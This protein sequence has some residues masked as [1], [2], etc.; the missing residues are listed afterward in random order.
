M[1]SLIML[2]VVVLA[3]LAVAVLAGRGRSF[4]MDVFQMLLRDETGAISLAEAAVLSQNDLQRGVIEAFIYE[5]Y[6][7]DRI[8]LLPIEGNAYAYNVELT[9]PGAAF[10]AVNAGYT[11]STGTVNQLT[12]T[13]K[14]LGGDADV[15]TF[16]Q[17]TRSNLNDQRAIQTTMKVKAA[18]VAYQDAFINGDTAVDA[19]E[20]DG[21]KKRLTG[22]QVI[23]TATNGLPIIGADDAARHLFLDKLDEAIDAVNGTPAALYMNRKAR[24]Q[25]RSSARRLGFWDRTRDEFGRRVETYN[26]IP[27]LDL[28]KDLAGADI[29]TVTETQ[30][31]SNVSSSIYV[32]AWSPDESQAGVTGLTNGGVQVR[33]LGEQDATPVLRTRIEFFC[34][35]AVFG[36]GASRLRGVLTP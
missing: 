16:I 1:Q 27:M 7:L 31:S 35:L 2:T 25:L 21:L 34:G 20:F 19:N 3:V 36:K 12:E 32:T 6:V 13:L 22:S 18:T 24:T 23:D 29:I 5:G 10:R 33:D 11:E 26:D 8:P 15:D 14:I 28:G 17:Q 30:G 4:S 9:L